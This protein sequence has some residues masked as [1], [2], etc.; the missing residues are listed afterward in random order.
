MTFPV[1]PTPIAP[2]AAQP[3]PAPETV[4]PENLMSRVSQPIPAAPE[5]PE[6]TFSSADIEKI[7]DP[8]VKKAITDLYKSMQSG[9]DKKF[10]SVAEERK[11]LEDEKTAMFSTW[12]PEKV[13]QITQHPSFIEASKSLIQSQAP[14]N[15]QGSQEEWS[16]LSENEKA[17]IANLESRV[18]QLVTQQDQLELRQAD[19]RI[20][21]KFSDYD[22]AK[23][24]RFQQDLIANRISAGEV[25]ELIWKAL[26]ADR[27][28]EQSYRFGQADRQGNVREKMAGSSTALNSNAVVSPDV[29]QK[30][31]KES[32]QSFFRRI[33]QARLAEAKGSAR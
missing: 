13:L 10:K 17:H 7:T 14:S 21:T 6:S 12:T 4:T 27:Y 31:E 18:N 5:T 26:N 9:Y 20:K 30:E 19:E 29:P 23:V 32:S 8:T 33:A 15:W 11:R 22:P 24:E 2:A 1:K 28:I 25:R 16:A 3:T